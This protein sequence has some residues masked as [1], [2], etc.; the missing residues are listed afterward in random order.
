MLACLLLVLNFAWAA[1]AWARDDWSVSFFTGFSATALRNLNDKKL[2]DTSFIP[3]TV[4]GSPA[5]RNRP[6]IGFE[7]E[8][9]VRPRLSLV[10]FTSYWEGSS[11]ALESGEANFQDQGLRPFEVDR[12]I[13]LSFN[14]YGLRTRYNLI[15]S[16]EQN[17]F[18]LEIGL[19]DQVRV[20]FREDFNYAFEGINGTSLRNIRSRAVGK[21]GY[22]FEWGFGGDYFL[23]NWLSI[24]LNANYRTGKAISVV[25]K[26]YEHTFRGV[27]GIEEASGQ[28][29]FPDGGDTV[30]Y[31]DGDFRKNL[32]LDLDG[33]QTSIGIRLYF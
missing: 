29:P 12:I 7:I 3:P 11:R 22:L 1:P 25:Y 26:S 23:S 16:A 20:T 31:I 15:E 27:D 18:Y 13:R 17:R 8:W 10:A 19:F 21:G 33:W 28:S 6:L 32:V 14:E 24:H 30:T 4:K 9:P 5:I 2:Q